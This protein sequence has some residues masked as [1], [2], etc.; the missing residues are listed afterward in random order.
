MVDPT[1]NPNTAITTTIPLGNKAFASPWFSVGR[2]ICQNMYLENASTEFAKAQYYLVKIP[3]LQRFGSIPTVNTG[4]CRGLFTASNYRTFTVNNNRVSEILSN[5][6]LSFIGYIG[7][8]SGPVSMAENG[9]LLMLV[10][11]IGGW[12]LRFTDNNWTR[13]TDE[14]FPGVDAGTLAPTKVTYLDTYFICNV[15]DTD[16]YYYST[17]Y[18]VRDHDDTSSPY[19][20]AEPNGYWTPLLSGRKIGKADNINCLINC[21][22]Y[23][24]LFGY[25]SCEI[26]YD[27][28]DFNGQLFARYQGAILN[29]G[30]KAPH[31]VA[32]FNNNIFFL[33]TDITGNLGVYSNEGMSLV[34]ISTVGIDQIIN[35]MS[36]W[37]DCIGYTYAQNSHQYYV[38]QFPRA[39]KTYVYDISNG[40]WHERTYLDKST[41]L[42]HAWKGL[43]ATNNFD[44]MIVG[45]NSSSAFYQLNQKYYLNDNPMDAGY[46]YIKCVKNTP[47]QF[48]NGVNVR[49]NWVQVIC[50]QGSG[51]TLNTEAGVGQEPHVQLS[52]SEFGYGP[53]T[54][55]A[56]E[57]EAPIGREGDY[58]K[59]TRVLAL[60]MGRNRV[61]NI[62]MSDP[63]PFILVG[64]LINAS[65]C[66]F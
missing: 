32:V 27:T 14:Y 40:S 7:S 30:C 2:E 60:G 18:Y 63:V 48:Q 34:K 38:M 52:W 61:Y 17:S 64:L 22:N 55:G 54:K 23:L 3:G 21:N 37:S 58:S 10:D 8:Y 16:Q 29:I 26:H 33:A 36:D 65:Q 25:N 43:F 45:D 35:E 44:K 13:I 12:I 59:R 66:R 42:L 53:G 62:A 4:A 20:P 9:K 11:G 24:W 46:N 5:G 56:N 19:D 57:R 51:L 31:S 6:S 41:G 1:I 39:D 49:Y 15:P 50:N 28:G 47:I